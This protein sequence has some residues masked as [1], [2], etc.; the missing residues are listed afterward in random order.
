MS[1]Y[2][3][4]SSELGYFGDG[5]P[6]GNKPAGFVGLMIAKE[7]GKKPKDY[8]PKPPK[9]RIPKFDINRVA[10]PSD[11]LKLAYIDS[12]KAPTAPRSAQAPAQPQSRD[13]VIVALS[14]QGMTTRQISAELPKYGFNASQPTVVRVLQKKKSNPVGSG[15]KRGG[16]FLTDAVKGM[17]TATDVLHRFKNDK[18]FRDKAIGAMKVGELAYNLGKDALKGGAGIRFPT[19]ATGI[20]FMPRIPV[21]PRLLMMGL[22]KGGAKEDE[23]TAEEEELFRQMMRPESHGSTDRVFR[24]SN[25]IPK[26]GYAISDALRPFPPSSLPTDIRQRIQT[27]M[28]AKDN[29]GRY[30]LELVEN[31]LDEQKRIDDEL[32]E[33][34]D[35]DRDVP[36]ENPGEGIGETADINLRYATLADLKKELFKTLQV[37]KQIKRAIVR[38]LMPVS[39]RENPTEADTRELDTTELNPYSD[40]YSERPYERGRSYIIK[41]AEEEGG[42]PT[43]SGKPILKLYTTSG[44]PYHGKYHIMPNGEVHTGKKHGARSKKL[45]IQ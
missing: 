29:W 43:G 18:A 7:Q 14:N 10:N 25:Q 16:N 11:Y 21:T 42:D 3:T 2:D 39:D 26:S 15:R 20:P 5:M 35:Q 31:I 9:K 30:R 32:E 28:D 12:Y 1:D 27:L 17:K 23:P 13:D 24:V 34:A 40:E 4:F 19:I 38:T 45:V 37:I 41:E 33:L 6:R 8:K 36:D 44:K 22:G